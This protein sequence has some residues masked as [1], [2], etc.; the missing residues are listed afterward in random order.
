[1]VLLLEICTS[2]WEGIGEEKDLWIA[3]HEFNQLAL[4]PGVLGLNSAEERVPDDLSR[5]DLSS[6]MGVKLTRS[7][8]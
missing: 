7:L 1:M 2:K 4:I 5:C 6:N 3:I 8:S